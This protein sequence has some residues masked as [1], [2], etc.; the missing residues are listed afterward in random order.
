M[1]LGLGCDLR[2]AAFLLV[3]VQARFVTCVEFGMQHIQL[4]VCALVVADELAL[5]NCQRLALFAALE[6]RS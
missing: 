5:R 4:G 3:Q 2:Q 1:D 6:R